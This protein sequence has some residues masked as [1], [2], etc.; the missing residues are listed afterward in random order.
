MPTEVRGVKFEGSLSAAEIARRV[1]REVRD[2]LKQGALPSGLLVSV[3]SS[4]YSMG[5]SVSVTVR[6]FSGPALNPARVFADELRCHE[7]RARGLYSAE[8]NAITDALEC[9]LAA[10]NRDASDSLTDHW[11]VHFYGGVEVRVDTAAERVALLES[12]ALADL[13][14]AQGA[15]DDLTPLLDAYDTGRKRALS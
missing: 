5:Q 3:R 11:D 15:G 10:Y 14:I 2:A 13:R 9:M 4:T 1:R 6:A 8:L 7:Y 12:E